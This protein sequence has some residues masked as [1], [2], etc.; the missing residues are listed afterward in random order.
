MIPAMTRRTPPPR[1]V[2]GGRDLSR[3]FTITSA[4]R[5]MVPELEITEVSVPG[6][7]RSMVSGVAPSAFDWNISGYVNAWRDDEVARTRREL[8]AALYSESALELQVPDD[9]DLSLMAL[10]K[11]GATPERHRHLPTT[12]LTFRVTDPVY[13]GRP[14]SAEVGGTETVMVG[15]T[16]KSAPV[17]TARPPSGSSWTIMNKSTGAF[18]RVWADFTGQQTL[19]LDMDRE[20]CRVNGY[21]HAVDPESDFFSISGACEVYVPSGTATLTWRERWV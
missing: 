16:W 12:E 9:P 11:G 21:D 19:E 1:L 14:R 18:V 5:P 10:Y 13:Y 6:S 15:G 4:P 8:D 20:R 3:L 17:V 2:F 7:G